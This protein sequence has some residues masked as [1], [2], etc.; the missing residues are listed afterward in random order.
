MRTR[1]DDQLDELHAAGANEV[2]PESLEGSLMLV[3]QVLSLT[4]V[5]FSRIVR[6]VQ[7]E[8]KNHYNHLHGFF[9][10][11]HTDMSPDAIDRIEFAHAI[12]LSDDSY[13]NGLTIGSLKLDERR[14]IVVALRRDDIETEE[15]NVDTV[16]QPQDTLIVR[17]KPR[18]VERAERFVQ[19]GH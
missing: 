1:N 11:E 3:S 7:K 18:R 2:V 15:P 4:G 19:E 17:G 10:G 12:I 14:V 6:R 5:P 16:L 8:R 9:Q 13:A